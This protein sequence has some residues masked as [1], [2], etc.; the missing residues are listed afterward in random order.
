MYSSIPWGNNLIQIICTDC[1]FLCAELL[2]DT[3][4]SSVLPGSAEGEKTERVCIEL[5]LTLGKIKKAL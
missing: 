1:C 3:E 2:W 5:T 4:V